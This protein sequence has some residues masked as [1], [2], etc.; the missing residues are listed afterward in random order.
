MTWLHSVFWHAVSM[1]S[2]FEMILNA[3]LDFM[4]NFIPEID[5]VC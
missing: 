2:R 1:I 3:C 5:Q 4:A